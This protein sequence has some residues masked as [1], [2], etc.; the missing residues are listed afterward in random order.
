MNAAR[1]PGPM[2]ASTAKRCADDPAFKAGYD[3]MKWAQSKGGATLQ[4]LSSDLD[5]RDARYGAAGVSWR[6]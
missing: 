4:S 3:A 1:E 6:A 2:S 5:A